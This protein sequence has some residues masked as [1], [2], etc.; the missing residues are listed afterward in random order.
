[1][2]N[3]RIGCAAQVRGRGPVDHPRRNTRLDTAMPVRQTTGGRMPPLT[4]RAFEFAVTHPVQ[5]FVAAV[6]AAAALSGGGCALV[7]WALGDEE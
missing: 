3:E 6:L 5:A 1:M 2:T 4:G 7:L